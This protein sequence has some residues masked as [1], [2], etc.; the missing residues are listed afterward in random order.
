VSEPKAPALDA[1]AKVQ[2]FIEKHF[3]SSDFSTKKLT[4]INP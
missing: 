3:L 2:H 1:G 4:G